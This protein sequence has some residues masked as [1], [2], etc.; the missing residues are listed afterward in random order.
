[1]EEKSANWG[2]NCQNI[3]GGKCANAVGFQVSDTQLK[4]VIHRWWNV[5]ASPKLMSICRQ[6]LL[7]LFGS[8]GKEEMD[9]NMER[10]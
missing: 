1:M 5:D 10:R 7:S 4:V 9:I 6:C 8:C 2:N 3:G